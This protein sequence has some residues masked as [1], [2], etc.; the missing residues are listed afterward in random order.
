[1][2]EDDIRNFSSNDVRNILKSNLIGCS[3]DPISLFNQIQIGDIILIRHGGEIIALTKAISKPRDVLPAEQNEYVWFSRCIEV[4]VLS[5]YKGLNV[6]GKGWFLPKTLMSVDND[7]V[8]GFI[9][10]LLKEIEMKDIINLLEYKKQIILQGPPGTGKTRLAE[11]V[12]VEMTKPVNLGNPIQKIDDFFKIYDVSWPEVIN[13]RK[14]L[15]DLLDE[16]HTRFPMESIKHLTL[17]DYAIG[18]GRN[19]SFCWWIERGLK[20]LGYYFPGSARAYLIYY[21]K[22]NEDYSKHGKLIEGIEDNNEAMQKVATTLS[23][24]ITHKDYNVSEFIGDSFLLKLLH[25]YYPDEYFPINSVPCLNNA[26]RLFGIDYSKMTP[27]EKN[28]RLQQVFIEKRKQYNKEI[29][30]HEFM[31]FLF[32]NFDLKGNIALRSNVVLSDGKYKIIQF[33]PAYTYEDFVRGISV[34][35]DG[36]S[37][38]YYEVENKILAEF[39]QDA[40]DNPSSKFILIIDEINR[41]NLP[42]VL[43]ELI[44]ALE[45]RYDENNPVSTSVESLYGLKANKD[46]DQPNREL[47]LP[48][49]LYIIGTMNTADRSVGHI[50]YAIRRRFAFVDIPPSINVLDEVIKDT[51]VRATAKTLYNSVSNL[52]SDG[53]IAPDF[54]ANEVQL[55][56]SYFLA[57][58]EAT[59]QLKLDYEIK[60]LL[61]E[62]LKDG[63]LLEQNE[64]SKTLD[65]IN[66]LSLHV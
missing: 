8:N 54:K 30:N 65:T 62:Y 45:Y 15:K 29:T 3:G 11:K 18:T 31:R 16:F 19:D 9:N 59:L 40:L 44:Y 63:I 50:D 28:L 52:F 20:P 37:Q 33:H 51:S 48:K 36:E 42:A 6:S 34:K 27:I 39:A 4:K 56:H 46:D 5:T 58:D 41:A 1:M 32:A 43:G 47:K 60:P 24:L 55:G 66:N 49:N 53:K 64:G 14:K 26:L 21:S 25:S 13:E 57:Q 7:I 2:H 23:E 61:R 10:N 35:V 22:K 17:E 38:V 12:G